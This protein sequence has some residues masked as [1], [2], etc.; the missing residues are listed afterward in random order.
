MTGS[1]SQQKKEGE[2]GHGCSC[3]GSPLPGGAGRTGS[4]CARKSMKRGR[5]IFPG[6]TICANCCTSCILAV[7]RAIIDPFTYS[8]EK[9]ENR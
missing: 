5:D 4:K 1:L 9:D 8:P 3:L 2:M 6:S 7:L